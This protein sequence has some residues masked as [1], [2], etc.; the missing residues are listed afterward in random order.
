MYYV[1]QKK[2]IFLFDGSGLELRSWMHIRDAI[3]IIKLLIF[4]FSKKKILNAP[5]KDVF[6]NKHVIS[7]IYKYL[8]IKNMPVFNNI[9]RKGDPKILIY[10][11]QDLKKLK[12]K[13][14]IP[15]SI[16]LKR[17]IKWFKKL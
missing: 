9:K 7:E 2:N 8:K 14:T 13:Q 16:G 17:Y 3:N 11:N 4:K 15:F 1:K 12:W 6:T 10:S 5:G